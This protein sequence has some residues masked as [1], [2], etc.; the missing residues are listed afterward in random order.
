MCRARP[1]KHKTLAGDSV[2]LSTPEDFD[3]CEFANAICE[4]PESSVGQPCTFGVKNNEL[5]HQSMRKVGIDRIENVHCTRLP[6]SLLLTLLKTERAG[7]HLPEHIQGASC[8]GS[9]RKAPLLFENGPSHLDA[10][11]I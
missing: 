8:D 5:C 4:P 9:P 7:H 1:L 10:R 2:P 3:S 11:K 6:R